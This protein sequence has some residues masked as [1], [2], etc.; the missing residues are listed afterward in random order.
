[1]IIVYASI[2]SR[3]FLI[4]VSLV[5]MIYFS[6]NISLHTI[7]CNAFKIKKKNYLINHH[8]YYYKQHAICKK[9]KRKINSKLKCCSICERRIQYK[10]RN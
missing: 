3:Y 2:F 7:I 8:H 4:K 5:L 1:M 6:Q 10:Q 9:A